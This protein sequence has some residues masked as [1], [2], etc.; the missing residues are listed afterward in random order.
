ML[1]GELLLRERRPEVG[2]ALAHQR[3]G[4]LLRGR[5]QAAI[6]RA[7]ALAGGESR[8]TARR[9]APDEAPDLPGT[10]PEL[11]GGSPLRQ[12]PLGQPRV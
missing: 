4:A 12:S 9:E 6:T 2:I 1:L 8:G 5:A 10:Q 7:A 11:L 3:Q